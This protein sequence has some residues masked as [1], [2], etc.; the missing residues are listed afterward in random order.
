[1]VPLLGNAAR[2]QGSIEETRLQALEKML[3]EAQ[4]RTSIIEQEAYD[5]AY[6]AGEKA[7]L[8]LGEKRAEQALA[9]L[10]SVVEQAQGE[11]SNLKHESMDAVLDISKAVVEHALGE[12]DGGMEKVLEKSVEQAMQSFDLDDGMGLTLLVNSHDLA[13]FSRLTSLPEQY[14]VK[15]SKEISAGTCRLIS[16]GQDALIAPKESMRKAIIRL[17]EHLLVA[18]D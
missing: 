6:A 11:L 18:D 15:A 8:A 1:M 7:G 14:K 2:K 4:S 9:L 16:Q 17:R 13:M 12:C 5:K 10:Q 3:H